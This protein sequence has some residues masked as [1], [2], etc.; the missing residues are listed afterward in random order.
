[1]VSHALETL[2]C[3]L[4]EDRIEKVHTQEY[5]CK[6]NFIQIWFLRG[7]IHFQ[8]RHTTLLKSVQ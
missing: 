3:V 2:L 7:L 6:N 5:L 1:M 8:A 4:K